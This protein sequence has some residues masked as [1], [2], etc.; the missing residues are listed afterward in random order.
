MLNMNAAQRAQ[1]LLTFQR[2][3]LSIANDGSQPATRV[4][5]VSSVGGMSSGQSSLGNAR[6]VTSYVGGGGGNTVVVDHTNPDLENVIW[7]DQFAGA[8]FHTYN[9]SYDAVM[10]WWQQMARD[11]NQQT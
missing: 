11:F 3:V 10:N 7:F 2:S 5:L 4:G 6:R 8:V 1:S 9:R